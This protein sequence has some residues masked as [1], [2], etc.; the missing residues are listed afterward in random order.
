MQEVAWHKFQ[1]SVNAVRLP[2]EKRYIYIH[3]AWVEEEARVALRL[4]LRLEQL[5]R[6]FR[7]RQT[8]RVLHISMNAQLKYEPIVL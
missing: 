6:I 1:T 4:E 2:G 8:S 7:A 5:S 3:S